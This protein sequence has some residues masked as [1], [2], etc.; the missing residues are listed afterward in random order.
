MKCKNKAQKQQPIKSAPS[1]GIRVDGLRK[2]YRGEAMKIHIQSWGEGAISVCAA[3][4]KR[5]PVH[6]FR[7]PSPVQ[8]TVAEEAMLR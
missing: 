2:S 6:L 3:L 1:D 5:A 8:P 7:M 4:H